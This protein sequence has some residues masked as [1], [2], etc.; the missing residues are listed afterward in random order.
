M[1]IYEHPA[2]SKNLSVLHK[3]IHFFLLLVTHLVPNLVNYNLIRG[4]MITERYSINNWMCVYVCML[5]LRRVVDR[6]NL[7]FSVCVLGLVNFRC[8]A[9]VNRSVSFQRC[10]TLDLIHQRFV[11]YPRVRQRFTVDQ[12]SHSEGLPR[13][14]L[15]GESRVQI[16]QEA[17]AGFSE[18]VVASAAA[19]STSVTGVVGVS[20]RTATT[21]A[22]LVIVSLTIGLRLLVMLLMLLGCW[23][24]CRIHS[25]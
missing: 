13:E 11:T 3:S 25:V 10:T 15:L 23:C 20:G 18:H 22:H 12:A 14:S 1:N 19:S 16:L 4:F 9:V 6:T 17:D 2:C 21:G 7:A 8:A 5:R 24:R